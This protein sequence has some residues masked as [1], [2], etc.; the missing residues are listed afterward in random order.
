MSRPHS[1]KTMTSRPIS[2]KVEI[3]WSGSS[4]DGPSAVTGTVRGYRG[5]AVYRR[6]TVNVSAWSGGPGL[7]GFPLTTNR[8]AAGRP[9]TTC[10]HLL[11]EACALAPVLNTLE[12]RVR[13][14]GTRTVM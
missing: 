11:V 7:R 5:P 6:R 4:Q 13:P 14:P 8:T 9:L 10:E 1:A 2:P 3:S 12:T